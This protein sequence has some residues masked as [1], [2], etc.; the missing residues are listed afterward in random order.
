MARKQQNTLIFHDF[1]VQFRTPLND[2]ERF[3]IYLFLAM[4]FTIDIHTDKINHVH[5]KLKTINKRK[6]IMQIPTFGSISNYPAQRC[7]RIEQLQ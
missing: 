2:I 1:N 7:L 4:Q 6:V 5:N 3:S